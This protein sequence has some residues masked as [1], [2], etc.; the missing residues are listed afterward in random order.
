MRDQLLAIFDEQMRRGYVPSEPGW[1]AEREECITRLVAPPEA[2]HGGVV[3]WSRLS[4]E[5]ADELISLQVL[6]FQGRPFEWKLYAHDASFDLGSRLVAAGGVPGDPESLMVGELDD[7]GARL[8]GQPPPGIRLRLI[9]P[10]ATADFAALALLQGEVWDDDF[11][12]LTAEIA[13]EQA[14]DPSRIQIW[15]AEDEVSGRPVSGA[16]VRFHVGSQFVSFWGGATLPEWRGRGM[17]RALVA[18]RVQEAA[19]RGFRWA[20]GDA[21]PDSKPILERLGFRQLS[22][23]IPYEWRPRG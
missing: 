14:A 16:W 2:T 7:V 23:T 13:A 1:T 17:Y 4:E 15:L 5:N 19:Q 20:Y 21:S 8:P 3:L 22:T 9:E 6:R 11:E 10:G 12:G 18:R